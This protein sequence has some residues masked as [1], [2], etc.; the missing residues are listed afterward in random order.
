MTSVSARCCTHI[1]PLL[2]PR[3]TVRFPRHF[4]A[5]FRLQNEPLFCPKNPAFFSA[6][7]TRENGRF[8]GQFLADLWFFIVGLD[9]DLFG[10]V[11]GE[12]VWIFYTT[13]PC[14]DAAPASF[15]QIGS[16]AAFVE[17]V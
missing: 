1:S 4:H 12:L 15:P 9:F 16:L 14:N 6:Q 7:N 11:L 13:A 3:K 10:C 2:T 8:P 17:L 5:A